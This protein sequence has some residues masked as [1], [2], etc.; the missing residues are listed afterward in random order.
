MYKYLTTKEKKPFSELTKREKYLV[1]NPNENK[2]KGFGGYHKWYT[3]R[4]T[5]RLG[6]GSLILG[7]RCRGWF[8]RD[9]PKKSR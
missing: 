4:N 9:K 6:D 1:E 5:R 8:W 3:V 7:C 2:N